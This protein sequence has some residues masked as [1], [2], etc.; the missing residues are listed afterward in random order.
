MVRVIL[1]LS[2]ESKG[3]DCGDVSIQ[4][5]TAFVEI[6]AANSEHRHHGSHR[7]C[8]KRKHLRRLS[9]TRC[10]L[11]SSRDHGSDHLVHLDGAGKSR[12]IEPIDATVRSSN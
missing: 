9:D 6:P 2:C 8:R 12:F 5:K 10:R 7:W 11:G 1:W 3:L 4:E